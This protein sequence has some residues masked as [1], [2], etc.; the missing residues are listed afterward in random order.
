M[1]QNVTVLG[2]SLPLL[3]LAWVSTTTAVIMSLTASDSVRLLKHY[4]CSC[5]CS[6]HLHVFFTRYDIL[7]WQ[8]SLSTWTK[9]SHLSSLS[10]PTD[11]SHTY[12]SHFSQHTDTSLPQSSVRRST[13]LDLTPWT[14]QRCP[15]QPMIGISVTLV[16]ST[17]TR[18]RIQSSLIGPQCGFGE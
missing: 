7:T 2:C 15:T 1:L 12:Y 9:Y 14:M 17:K 8:H 6:L 16:S 11:T 4:I 3:F 13:G 5:Q 18:R 10:Q